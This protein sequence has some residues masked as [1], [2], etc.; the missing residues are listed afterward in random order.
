MQLII[1]SSLVA[2]RRKSGTVDVPDVR[3]VYALFIDE[4]ACD[5]PVDL[6]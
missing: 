4:S 3:R 1:A 2:R 6:N 5:S